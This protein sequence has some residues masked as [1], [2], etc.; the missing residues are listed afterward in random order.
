MQYVLVYCCFV[1]N[2]RSLLENFESKNS[3]VEIEAYL[4]VSQLQ[5]RT[6]WLT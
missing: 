2:A 5:A 1:S 4:S 6:E 3:I